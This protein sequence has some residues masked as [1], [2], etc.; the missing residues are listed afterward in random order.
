MQTPNAIEP[1]AAQSHDPVAGTGSVGFL[2]AIVERGSALILV[3]DRAGAVKYVN[4]T[5]AAVLEVAPTDLCGRPIGD[6]MH[7]EESHATAAALSRVA[8]DAAHRETIAV[9]LAR[10]RG[11][12]R[13]VETTITNML[14]DPSVAGVVFECRDL[15]ARDETQR[16]YRLMFEQSTV[17]QALIDPERVGLIANNAFARMFKTSR[18]QLRT[19][20]P[21]RLAHPDHSARL[22]Q[23]IGVLEAGELQHVF[24]ELNFVRSDGEEFTGNTTMT[25]LRRLD[26]VLDYLFIA[27]EDVSLERRAAQALA[28]SQARACALV[29]NSPDIIAILYPDGEW[30]ASDQGTRLL[31]YPKGFDPVGGVFSLIHPDDIRAASK[32]LAEVLTGAR[33]AS[34]PIELRLRAADGAYR[35]FECVGQNLENDPHIGGVVITARDIS[36]RKQ[37][38]AKLRA[39]EERFRVAFEHAPMIVSMVDLEGVLVDIN[40]I[41]CEMLGLARAEIVGLPAELSVH[42][43]DRALAIE[44]TTRQLGGDPVAAEF[45][46]APASGEE[47]FVLSRAQLVIDP[48]GLEPPYVITLQADITDRKQ[49]ER[50]LERRAAH[51]DLTG[52]WNRSSLI[53]HLERALHSRVAR[54]LAVM[55]ID[56]DDFKSINDT[57]GHD[58]G[59]VVLRVTAERI[60]AVARVSDLASRWGGDE[61][62][63]AC[64]QAGSLAEIRGIAERLRDSL[65]SPMVYGRHSIRCDVSIGVAVAGD[66]DDTA[67]LVDRA[68]AATYAAKRAG[69]GRIVVVGTEHLPA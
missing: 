16:R 23:E 65:K 2:R 63:V 60:T 53:D 10:G 35:D 4:A 34:L 22:V 18:E 24:G 3:T 1:G 41:G 33:A 32:A 6:L 7:P 13:P 69:K 28:R 12:W 8:S 47:I 59:D 37:A 44:L 21:E 25:A 27:I 29:D 5:A 62:I 17:A 38:Q 57:L 55:F 58:A 49:L 30:E 66:D 46:L 50:E 48:E 36:E 56:L 67:S 11:R 42:P 31:G 26:G 64:E 40:P 43:D 14:D 45:R 51:D 9:H 52:L 19:T 20:A 61:F 54:P 39:A 15:T 68:D